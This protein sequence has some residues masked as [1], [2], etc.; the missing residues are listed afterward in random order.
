M[1]VI[2]FWIASPIYFSISYHTVPFHTFFTFYHCHVS[3]V[4]IDK[5]TFIHHYYP[6]SI[7]T[8]HS[9]FCAVYV[10]EKMKNDMYAS[11]W[12]HTEQFHSSKDLLSFPC[13]FVLSL[14]K[15]LL[16]FPTLAEPKLL[17]LS[18][19]E[20]LTFFRLVYWTW[21]WESFYLLC[22]CCPDSLRFYD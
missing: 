5:Y 12:Y 13:S 18:P 15:E 11:L 14:P 7:V 20:R 4:T 10:F 9:W 1:T 16:P 6:I 19:E 17:S 22:G 2:V 21:H 8:L 3:F